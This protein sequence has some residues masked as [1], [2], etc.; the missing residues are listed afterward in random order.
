MSWC[1]EC[2]SHHIGNCSR[3]TEVRCYQCNEIGH[4]AYDYPERVFIEQLLL[5]IS[6]S[7]SI[8]GSR[9][10]N[11]NRVQNEVGAN[12]GSTQKGHVDQGASVVRSAQQI[13]E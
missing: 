4:Y 8:R 2:K 13:R 1:D 3:R 9:P 6:A 10:P 12:M 11:Y 5:K 7:H